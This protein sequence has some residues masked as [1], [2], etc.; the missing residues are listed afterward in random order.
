MRGGVV[1]CNSA[2]DHPIPPKRGTVPSGVR[3]RPPLTIVVRWRFRRV[4]SVDRDAE[5]VVGDDGRTVEPAG[6]HLLH[7]GAVDLR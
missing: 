1:Q 2:V 7:V 4:A 3:L 5:Q 6:P